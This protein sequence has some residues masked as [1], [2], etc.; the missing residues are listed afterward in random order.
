MGSSP[1]SL[2]QRVSV[3]DTLNDLFPSISSISESLSSQLG[4][5]VLP[6]PFSVPTKELIYLRTTIRYLISALRVQP[7][8]CYS[9]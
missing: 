9:P 5:K 4:M 8:D 7:R 6:L 1:F 3:P 2:F